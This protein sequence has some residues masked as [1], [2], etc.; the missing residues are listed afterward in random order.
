[1]RSLILISSLLLMGLL[2]AA[3]PA[4]GYKY[5]GE[6]DVEDI[7]ASATEEGDAAAA[8]SSPEDVNAQYSSLQESDMH[9]LLEDR[10]IEKHNIPTDRAELVALLMQ[11]DEVEQLSSKAATGATGDLLFQICSG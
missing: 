3:Q 5:R 11:T 4:T 7:A 1:M 6:R 8:A 2:L 9:T 10:G